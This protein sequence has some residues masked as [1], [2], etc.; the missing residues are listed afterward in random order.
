[1]YIYYSLKVLLLHEYL[2]HD[3]WQITVETLY[4][5]YL[6]AVYIS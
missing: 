6:Q 1:M 5:F 4:K 3:Y 2:Q